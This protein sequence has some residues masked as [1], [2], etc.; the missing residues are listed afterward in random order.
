MSRSACPRRTRRQVVQSS[1]STPCPS[2]MMRRRSASRLA[3]VSGVISCL[4][5]RVTHFRKSSRRVC[6]SL[7][8][9]NLGYDRGCHRLLHRALCLHG[10]TFPAGTCRGRLLSRSSTVFHLL[11]PGP[12]PRPGRW[13]AHACVA[14]G[15]L[16]TSEALCGWARVRECVPV[17]LHFSS[18]SSNVGARA[19]M[20]SRAGFAAFAGRANEPD[21]CYPPIGPRKAQEQC[22]P[23]SY[24]LDADAR[25]TDKGA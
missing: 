9:V 23:G 2:R 22:S 24:S 18:G 16:Y 11:V 21:T 7:A 12:A 13:R 10:H 6:G 3:C 4:R 20:Y 19:D 1:C 25:V 5:Y 8:Q 14:A 15:E 17:R